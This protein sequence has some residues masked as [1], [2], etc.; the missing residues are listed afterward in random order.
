[1]WYEYRQPI[2]EILGIDAPPHE[3]VDT[4]H[5]QFFDL[6]LVKSCIVPRGLND[7]TYVLY[8]YRLTAGRLASDGFG[9]FPT[10]RGVYETSFEMHVRANEKILIVIEG[11]HIPMDLIP[12]LRGK[13][14]PYVVSRDL[15]DTARY[16][17]ALGKEYASQKTDGQ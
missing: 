16:M 12:Y 17:S 6:A 15:L 8:V 9:K 5:P 2:F 10:M 13:G 11:D 14:Y 4:P 7:L 1:M 3:R